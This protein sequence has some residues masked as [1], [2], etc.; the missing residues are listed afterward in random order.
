MGNVGISR[1]EG[2]PWLKVGDYRVDIGRLNANLESAFMFSAFLDRFAVPVLDP[3]SHGAQ[4]NPRELHRAMQD[5]GILGSG[6]LGSIIGM[7]RSLL[8][9]YKDRPAPQDSLFETAANATWPIKMLAQEFGMVSGRFGMPQDDPYNPKTNL[10]KLLTHTTF[11]LPF[12]KVALDNEIIM[13]ERNYKRL[14]NQLTR[15]LNA[16]DDPEEKRLIGENMV[17]IQ[18]ALMNLTLREKG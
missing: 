11:G 16:T 1:F 13:A 8:P 17:A 3:I 10:E 18:N 15:R 2:K 4:V 5:M 6:G 12:K 14:N 7:N 9:S